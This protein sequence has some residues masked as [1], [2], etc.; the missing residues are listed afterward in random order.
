MYEHLFSFYEILNLKTTF[1][2]FPRAETNLLVGNRFYDLHISF[3]KP[4]VASQ[5]RQTM[6]Y[7]TSE[8]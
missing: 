7:K 3:L 2:K 8:L 4:A 6:L 5:L 1:A